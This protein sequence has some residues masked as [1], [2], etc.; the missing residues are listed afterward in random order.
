[1]VPTIVSAHISIKLVTMNYYIVTALGYVVLIAAVIGMFRFKRID[2]TYY[3]V[4]ILMIIA[5]IN[6]IVSTVVSFQK[7]STSINNNVFTLLEAILIVWQFKLWKV[8][9]HE[10]KAYVI[11]I[12]G[13]I[14]LWM[15]E[16]I[17]LPGTSQLVA[18]CRILFSF[19]IVVMAMFMCSKI[20]T[21]RPYKLLR[22]SS[23]LICM[24]FCIFF[25]YKIVVQF[26]WLYGMKQNQELMMHVLY[27]MSAINLIVNIIYCLAVLWIP[28]KPRFITS[29]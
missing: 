11:I 10:L 23:F 28:N 17:I 25:T 13:M 22:Q 26:F 3:P 7:G 29:S 24:G 19:T 14:L 8:F 27:L 15:L 5:S 2:R 1:M 12:S 18:I 21:E 20:I 16:T 6:E 4:L 9:G